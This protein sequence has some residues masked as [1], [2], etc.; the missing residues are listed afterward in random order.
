M[1]NFSG[2]GQIGLDLK[3]IYL[4][5]INHPACIFK[6]LSYND[7]NFLYTKWINKN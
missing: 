4:Y 3:Q 2:G 1:M 5:Y 7:F 6:G